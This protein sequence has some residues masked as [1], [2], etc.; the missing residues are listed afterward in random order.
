MCVARAAVSA[1]PSLSLCLSFFLSLAL[2]VLH[3]LI[4]NY[5]RVRRCAVWRV[6]IC[7]NTSLLKYTV[8][9]LPVFP[10]TLSHISL[11]FI[12]FLS[13]SLL[14]CYYFI[15]FG[16]GFVTLASIK[17]RP[18]CVA[19]VKLKLAVCVCAIVLEARVLVM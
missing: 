3:A 17:Y 13:L 10:P 5:R 6:D 8:S 7:S 16:L 15:C 19:L 2:S 1:S 4:N 14:K 9:I 12:I 18:S 11:A